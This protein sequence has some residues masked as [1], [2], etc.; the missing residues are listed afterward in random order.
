MKSIGQLQNDRLS[1]ALIFLAGYAFAVVLTYL[2]SPLSGYALSLEV[3]ARIAAGAFG[4]SLIPLCVAV[5]VAFVARK[6]HSLPF[7]M[8]FASMYAG[9]MI[10]VFAWVVLR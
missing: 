5:T 8:Y 9:L 10:A 3:A 4:Y 2:R 7:T 1:P 6:K